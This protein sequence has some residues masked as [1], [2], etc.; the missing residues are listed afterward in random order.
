MVRAFQRDPGDLQGFLHADPF[1]APG[2]RPFLFQIAVLPALE[3]AFESMMGAV[4]VQG[5]QIGSAPAGP[6]FIRMPV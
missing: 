5:V 2:L 1:D 4:V 3:W 6:G